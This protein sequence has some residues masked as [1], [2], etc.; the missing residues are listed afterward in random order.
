MDGAYARARSRS[1]VLQYRYQTRAWIACQAGQK[2]LPPLDADQG[3]TEGR[4]L[5]GLRRLPGGRG[6]FVGIE[7]SQELIRSASALPADAQLLLGDVQDPP[8]QRVPTSRSIS[9]LPSP[10]SNMS[11]ARSASLKW[12]GV[13]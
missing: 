6:R 11:K 13:S 8:L 3:A 12:R 2:Q 1:R 9:F 4:T 10:C 5:V 7:E